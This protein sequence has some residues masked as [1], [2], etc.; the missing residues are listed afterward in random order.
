MDSSDNHSNAHNINS[1]N[2]DD[3]DGSHHP[4][5]DNNSDDN[6]A[7]VDLNPL[8]V[9]ITFENDNTIAEA[10]PAILDNTTT[11]TITTITTTGYNS[12]HQSTNQSVTS[13]S[14]HSSGFNNPSTSNNHPFSSNQSI[15]SNNS[16]CVP[17]MAGVPVPGGSIGGG[18][19]PAYPGADKGDVDAWAAHMQQLLVAKDNEIRFLRQELA[20]ANHQLHVLGATRNVANVALPGTGT[21]PLAVAVTTTNNMH[22]THHHKLTALEPDATASPTKTIR[23]SSSSSKT[24]CRKPKPPKEERTRIENEIITDPYGD[25]GTYTGMILKATRM[26]HGT[27]LMKYEGDNRVYDGQWRYGRWHGFGK[28]FFANGDTYVGDYHMDQRHGQGKYVWQNGRAYDGQF[29]EDT[30]HGEGIF[31]WPDG[32]AYVSRDSWVL[33]SWGDSLEMCVPH[34]LFRSQ[35]LLYRT[36]VGRGICQWSARGTRYLCL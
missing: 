17:L 9:D 16:N 28:A 20:S 1:S 36:T 31:V 30:R 7:A 2:P 13:R 4:A 12:S 18:S 22:G 11:T 27:G 21:V 23:R 32:S 19:Y 15:A 26:P 25:Q 14:N 8:P 24:S 6:N 34:I 33:E 10:V 3:G 29:Y 35:L 5:S